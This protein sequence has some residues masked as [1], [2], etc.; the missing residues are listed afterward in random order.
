[1]IALS[2]GIFIEEWMIAIKPNSIKV[3]IDDRIFLVEFDEHKKVLRIKERKGHTHKTFWNIKTNPMTISENSLV[4]RII[5]K[6][7][8]C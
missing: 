8:V 4:S 6:A 1:M 7:L 5:K 2:A 3:E